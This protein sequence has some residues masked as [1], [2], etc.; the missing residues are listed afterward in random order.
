[1]IEALL[2]CTTTRRV[3]TV[4]SPPQAA[5]TQRARFFGWEVRYIMYTNTQKTGQ[6]GRIYTRNSALLASFFKTDFLRG[7]SSNLA[8]VVGAWEPRG[9]SADR[10]LT[11]HR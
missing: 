2:V 9:G 3:A 11:A 4:S 1:M 7:T 5:R 8:F 6:A 10:K